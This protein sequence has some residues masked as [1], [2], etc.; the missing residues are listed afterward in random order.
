MIV[1]GSGELVNPKDVLTSTEISRLAEARQ[2]DKTVYIRKPEEVTATPASR[3]KQDGAL[4]WHFRMEHTRDVSW[5]A[6]PVFVWDAA[7]MNLP[8]GKHLP[9]HERLP[10]RKCWPR[11]VG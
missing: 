2:S 8:E 9:S 4:T 5:T 10:A 6:S 1:A 11:Q 7:R 3:P